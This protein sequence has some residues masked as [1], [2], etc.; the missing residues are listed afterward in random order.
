MLRRREAEEVEKEAN[1]STVET[2]EKWKK[3]KV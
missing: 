2:G 3:K 1:N